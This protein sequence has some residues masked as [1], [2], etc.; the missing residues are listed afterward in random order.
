MPDPASLLEA[1]QRGQG[2]VDDL[3]EVGELD[4]VALQQVHVVDAEPRT[5][6]VEAARDAVGREV[7]LALA[8]LADLGCEEVT[9]APDAPQR[10]SEHRLGAGRAIVGR[11]VDEVDPVVQRGMDR[12]HGLGVVG[13]PEDAAERGRAEAEDGDAESGAAERTVLHVR[14]TRAG[15]WRTGGCRRCG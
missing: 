3:V 8:I 12:A 13:G 15:G 10:P 1:E 6:L 7:E 14:P 11:H 4:V 2:L 9:V 5:T